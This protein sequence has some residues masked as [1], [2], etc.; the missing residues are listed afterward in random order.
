MKNISFFF[1]FLF[2]LPENVQFSEVKFSI[3]LNR[4]VFVM[5][6]GFCGC[7]LWGFFFMFCCV[8]ASS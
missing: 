5:L 2:F 8:Q 3:Y 6:C 4:H 7:L 1:F